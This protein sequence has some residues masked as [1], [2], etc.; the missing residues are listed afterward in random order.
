MFRHPIAASVLSLLVPGLG[1]ILSG[2]SDRGAAILLSTIVVGNLNAIFLSLYAM[3]DRKIEAFWAQRLPRILHDL[4]A[5]Y[6]VV[7]WVWQVIDAYRVANHGA[8]YTAGR[9]R[10]GEP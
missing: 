2:K 3:A 5:A 8:P 4:F 1:Q 7:F 6:G 10:V 9:R